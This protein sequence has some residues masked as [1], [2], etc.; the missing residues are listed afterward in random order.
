MEIDGDKFSE[1][2]KK[3]YIAYFLEKSAQREIT[4]KEWRR[5][6]AV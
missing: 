2:E 3:E 5:G 1:W 6:P 4:K